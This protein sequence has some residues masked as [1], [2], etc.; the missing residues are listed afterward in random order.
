[1]RGATARASLLLTRLGGQSLLDAF[2]LRL[3]ALQAGPLT[4]APTFAT[5]AE[6]EEAVRASCAQAGAIVPVDDIEDVLSA[7][8]PDDWVL[9][10]DPLSF[11]L[12]PVHETSLVERLPR[13]REATHLVTMSRNPGGIADRVRIDRRG[14][15]QGIQRYYDARTTFVSGVVCTLLPAPTFGDVANELMGCDSLADL[16]FALAR[17]GVPSRDLPISVETLDLEHEGN[18][19]RVTERAIIDSTA[20]ERSTRNVLIDRS[21]RLRGPVSLQQHVVI[22]AEAIVVGPT[23]LADGCRIG[24]GA[25]VAQCLIGPGVIVPPHAVVRHRAIF[26]AAGLMDLY[27]SDEPEYDER[28]AVG[29][30]AEQTTDAATPIYP[31]IKTITDRLIACLALLVLSPLFALVA[32]LIRIDSRGPVFYGD[33]RETIGGRLFTCWK[34]RTMRPD[35]SLQ[36]ASLAARNQMDGP[37]FKIDGDPRITRLGRWLRKVSIDEL[38]QLYNVVRGDMSLVGPRPSPFRENQ[39]CV[40]WRQGRLSVR[41]GI[42]GLWQVCR[43]ER[44]RG[45]FHQWIEYDTMYVRHMSWAVDLRIILATIRTFGGARRVPYARII[46]APRPS[47]ETPVPAADAA[48]ARVSI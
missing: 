39:I 28:L 46:R 16:R 26:S 14:E 21:A 33:L 2:R 22:D 25:I 37:Q 7:C 10:A 9:I 48:P 30:L 19:L 29:G 20:A 27:Q 18:L 43:D 12:E 1:M 31:A 3:P 23:V 4:V 44:T 42:T 8:A 36:Q 45:D 40:P 32:L 15:V 6:Y 24:T 13:S 34:F 41:A 35:A 11:P 5:T 47:G 38:P 17:L